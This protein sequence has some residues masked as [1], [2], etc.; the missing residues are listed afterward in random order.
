MTAETLKVTIL[1]CGSSGGVPRIGGDWGACDPNEP[2]NRRLRCS[3]L[4][5]REGTNMLV[6]TSPDMRE[7]LL[8]ARVSHLHGVLYTH[9]HA[10]QANGIDDLRMVVMN[11]RKRID[12]YADEIT[13]DELNARFGYCFSQAEGSSYPAILNGHLIRERVRVDGPGGMIEAVSFPVD[14]G[15]AHCVGFRFGNF[16]YTP[17][18]ARMPEEAFTAV[19]GAECWIVDCL[20]YT[21]H[22]THS[23]L[24]RTLE[25]IARV[26]PKLAVLT[27]LHIDLDYRTLSREL[28]E[29]VIP[30]Y[31][32]LVLEF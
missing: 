8:A 14:H 23:H 16:A 20:R 28:P 12:V 25:W 11:M 27:N 24:A 7:Q 32:G 4:V 6:D 31:D 22:P 3:I 5:Q 2:R 21:P 17:D 19:E 30:A 29:G 1:G 15:G 18:I 10:D 13:F 9:S 26:Q